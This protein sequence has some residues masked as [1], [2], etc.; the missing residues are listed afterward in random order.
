MAAPADGPDNGRFRHIMRALRCEERGVMLALQLCG[1][2]AVIAAGIGGWRL[3]RGVL[4]IL[5]GLP[6]CNDDLIFF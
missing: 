6:A 1:A 5:P 2:A 3:A 4:A